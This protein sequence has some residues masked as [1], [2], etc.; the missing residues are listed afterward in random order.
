MLGGHHADEYLFSFFFLFCRLNYFT[1]DVI[2]DM[3][4]GLPMGFV[5]NG[6]DRKQAQTQQGQFYEVPATID[7]LHQGV[8]YA[9]TIAQAVSIETVH[10][11]QA[12]ATCFPWVKKLSKAKYAED[13]EN[14]C[15]NQLR[16]VSVQPPPTWFVAHLSFALADRSHLTENGHWCCQ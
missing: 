7:A 12:A 3:A 15:I 5:E 2:G 8:R 13:W 9:V 4:F 14:I 6:G 10:R 11:L 16:R 1:L